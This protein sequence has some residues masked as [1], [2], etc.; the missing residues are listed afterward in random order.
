MVEQFIRLHSHLHGLEYVILRAANPFGP[1]QRFRRGQGLIPALLKR[2]AA[3]QPITI[4]GDGSATRD[5]I[6]IDDLVEAT[7]RAATLPGPQQQ[8][9]NIGTGIHRSVLEVV[10]TIERIT[11]VEFKIEYAPQREADVDSI[12]L[13]IRRARDV[14]G[15][16]PSTNFIDGL[17][18]TCD[19]RDAEAAAS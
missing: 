10:R 6:Y 4:F 12:A 8:V 17:T 2:H 3:G 11:G 19:A 5:Y 9:L 14:L 15:W 18:R 13:D 7:I 1:G 16:S